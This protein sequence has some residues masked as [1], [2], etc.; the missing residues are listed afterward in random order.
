VRGQ[1][2]GLLL[3][4]AALAGCKDGDG[5]GKEPAVEP[6]PEPVAGDDAGAAAAAAIDALA[7]IVLPPAPEVARAPLGLPVTPSPDH[8]RTTPAKVVLGELLFFDPRLSGDATMSCA[9][10]HQ[11]EHGWAA[12]EQ[13]SKTAGGKL[14]LRHTPS[15]LNAGYARSWWWDGRM[16]T[17]EAATLAHW[18]GQLGADPAP[19]AAVLGAV[20]VYAAH[21]ERAFGGAAT[22]DM[23]AEALASFVRTLRSG[24]SPWDQ[25]EAGDADAVTADVVE[26]FKVF[27]QKA[28]CALCHPPP[29][30]SDYG[31]HNL[32]V[33]AGDV[34][35]DVGRVRVTRRDEDLGAFKTPT[36]RGAATHPP[37]FHDGSADTLE[38]AVDYILAGG[39]REGNPAIAP[40]LDPVD[41]TPME[42]Q[43]LLLFLRSLTPEREPYEPPDLP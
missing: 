12:P 35:N 22:A 32:G 29:L 42:R 43:Q 26:G 40:R 23:V 11:P 21:F 41:L 20:P 24:N 5:T 8:N 17:L 7:R 33:G 13:R 31:F 10:C 16:D 14:N 30:Y 6:G 9:S 38:D 37:F 18:K 2:L 27:T 39:H 15:L 4:A 19:M 34:P 3:A 36:L 1:I 25:H 28:Q